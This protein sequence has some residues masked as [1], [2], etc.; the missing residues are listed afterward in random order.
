MEPETDKKRYKIAVQM[1]GGRVFTYI[2]SSYDVKD[3][4]IWFIDEQRG[5]GVGFG[6]FGVP[7]AF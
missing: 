2:V 1:I 4:I 5:D 3:G 6:V 7:G